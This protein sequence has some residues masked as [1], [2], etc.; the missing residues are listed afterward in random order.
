MRLGGAIEGLNYPAEVEKEYCQLY[1]RI[2]PRVDGSQGQG[3]KD[4]QRYDTTWYE[5]RAEP[6]VSRPFL[7]SP[8]RRSSGGSDHGSSDS[9]NLRP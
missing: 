3:R 1:D 7:P 4:D 8:P 5:E 2:G 9:S 6:L